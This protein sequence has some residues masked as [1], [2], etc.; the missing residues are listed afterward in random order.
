MKKCGNMETASFY[1]A[2]EAL[3]TCDEH[4]HKE[5]SLFCETC[6]VFICILCAKSNHQSHNWNLIA[7][8]AEERRKETPKLCRK[9]KQGNL[10]KWLENSRGIDNI[11]ERDRME[12]RQKLEDKRVALINMINHIVDEQKQE[13]DELARDLIKTTTE[14]QRKIKYLEKM[15]TSLDINIAA[16]NDFDIIEMEQ[17][18]LKVVTEVE[19]YDVNRALSAVKFIQGDV[20]K[21]L[22]EEMIG[23][24]ENAM[25]IDENEMETLKEFAPSGIIKSIVPISDTTAWVGDYNSNVIKLLSC[26]DVTT[27]Q[28]HVTLDHYGDFI[29]FGHNDF[30]VAYQNHEIRRVT[31]A[32]RETII[33]NTK[34]L[35]PT[36][37]SNTRTDDILVTMK[38]GGKDY[39]LQPS[40]RRMVQRITPS[41]EVLRTYEFKGDDV[42][43]LFTYPYRT[44]E[45]RNSDICV[46]NLVNS[47]KGKLIV[48]HGDGRLR[49]SYRGQEG[50]GF[51]PSDVACDSKGRIIISDCTNNY[52]RLL[53]MEGTFLK[54]LMPDDIIHPET[55][56]IYG[57]NLW[58]GF[59]DGIVKLYK[60]IK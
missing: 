22:I 30:I 37:I 36:W 14:W 42:T 44:A 18:M 47:C 17:E 32:G 33:V 26:D 13:R 39:I 54:D 3:K 46:I 23:K 53:N 49:F 25:A 1:K 5:L 28:R 57:R 60:Y 41:G 27:N 20:D 15:T 16:Y 35:Y 6:K 58:V 21:G 50:S 7:S 24:F 56:A 29:T 10:S 59:R 51:R 38:D 9:I 34:P 19:S 55:I 40:S 52:L 48:L 8:I 45:N 2:Q 31:S 43:R 11:V 4:A 12:D